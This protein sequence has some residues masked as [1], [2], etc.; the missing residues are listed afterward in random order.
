MK[1]FYTT[2]VVLYNMYGHEAVNEKTIVNLMC[3][4]YYTEKKPEQ[5]LLW[6]LILICLMIFKFS[7]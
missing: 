4:K 6:F 7:D 2:P 3:S 5:T 1:Y